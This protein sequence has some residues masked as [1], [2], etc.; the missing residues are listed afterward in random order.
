[1]TAPEVIQNPGV[2][3]SA[4]QGFQ[5]GFTPILQALQ[6]RRQLEVNRAQLAI[7]KQR[8]DTMEGFRSAE[9][10]KYQQDVADRAAQLDAATRAN[11][12]FTHL[13]QTGAFG[14]PIAHAQ[15]PTKGTP[16]Q[17]AITNALAGENGM[18]VNAFQ[19]HLAT[20][21]QNLAGLAKAQQDKEQADAVARTNRINQA[22]DSVQAKYQGK[23]LTDPKLQGQ[24]LS[25]LATVSPATAQTA[26][27]AFQKQEGDFAPIVG[28]NG[29]VYT[30]NKRNGTVTRAGANVGPKGSSGALTPQET[31]IA[32]QQ[33]VEAADRYIALVR[34]DPSA[35]I[36]STPAAMLQGSAGKSVAGVPI[37]GLA[38]LGQ[39][40]M[41][42][43]QQ[44][45]KQ[46]QS[47]FIA[48]ATTLMPKSRMSPTIMN[49]LLGGYFT[50]AGSSPEARA[51]ALQSLLSYRN[52][53][54]S[55]RD[56]KVVNMVALPG[57][58]ETAQAAAQESQGGPIGGADP[59]A[60][61]KP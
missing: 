45:A 42:P 22:V 30:I 61:L 2:V 33:A 56:G 46:L 17:Q 18:V 13:A 36:P 39:R 40:L 37:G 29:E 43:N 21:G 19:Q 5:A 38:P 32:A 4:L 24:Y 3:Q 34:Q 60:Y 52:Q 11:Q 49:T 26:A 20:Y 27:T 54:A 44:V 28:S 55:L 25:D 12:I 47:Q 9:A 58:K 8:A 48:A 35:A 31:Q 53:L 7:D 41:T 50:P 15:D 57:F 6:F 23:N 59:G 51:Q 10:Q 16:D 1:M 14:D